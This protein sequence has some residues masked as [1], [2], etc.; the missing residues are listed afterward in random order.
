[1][2]SKCY[3]ISF[4][5]PLVSSDDFIWIDTIIKSQLEEN[6][7]DEFNESDD[8]IV[9]HPVDEHGDHFRIVS[10]NQKKPRLEIV[11]AAGNAGDDIRFIQKKE[12]FNLPTLTKKDMMLDKGPWSDAPDGVLPSSFDNGSAK[13]ITSIACEEITE[14]KHC[15]ASSNTDSVGDEFSAEGNILG[16]MSVVDNNNTYS[17][18]LGQIPS[19]DNGLNFFNNDSKD[20]EEG[21]ILYYGWPDDIGNFEDVD[22]MFR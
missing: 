1:M 8:H 14:S 2:L 7:W 13:D 15:L 19:T 18:S 21:D 5:V 11:G 3:L 17:F 4:I 22:R 10:D 12:E 20:R 9:P 6:V 16:E